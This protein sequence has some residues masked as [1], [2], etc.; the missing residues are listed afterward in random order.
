MVR[1]KKYKVPYIDADGYEVVDYD[2][3]A[4]S[5]PK[6]GRSL[7]DDDD[8]S[9]SYGSGWS[10]YSGGGWWNWSN[11]WWTTSYN[12]DDIEQQIKRKKRIEKELEQFKVNNNIIAKTYI[13]SDTSLLR[14]AGMYTISINNTKH[15]KT[16][17]QYLQKGLD[18]WKKMPGSRKVLNNA[19]LLSTLI[20]SHISSKLP[21][22]F[23][24]TTLARDGK[25]DKIKELMELIQTTM[26]KPLINDADIDNL[27]NAFPEKIRDEIEEHSGHGWVSTLVDYFTTINK[28]A[29]PLRFTKPINQFRKFP[30][31]VKGKRI[32]KAFIQK[33]DYRVFKRK[34]KIVHKR[35]KILLLLDAS[36]SMSWRAYNTWVNFAWALYDLDMFDIDMYQTTDRRVINTTIALRNWT[37]N[38]SRN[39]FPGTHNAEWFEALTTRLAW[40]DRDEDYV[41]VITDML[42][43]DNAEENLKAF[44]GNKKHMILSF[45]EKWKFGC[46]VRLVKKYEDMA[47]VVTSLLSN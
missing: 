37:Q 11:K 12:F 39:K 31:L 36:G 29:K 21:E 46:N 17:I 28:T 47:N 26:N 32:N 9:V 20:S 14:K 40:I 24:N 23:E 27:I 34:E 43:P 8:P 19:S 2:S 30:H 38:K 44:I 5:T 42:V 13:G 33:L 41:L 25:Y 16:D 18:T 7:W 4:S 6:W 1:K 22:L 15:Y 45:Q 3:T 10:K 35:K